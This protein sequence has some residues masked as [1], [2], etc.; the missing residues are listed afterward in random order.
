MGCDHKIKT[1]TV[2]ENIMCNRVHGGDKIHN[3]LSRFSPFWK[4]WSFPR[5]KQHFFKCRYLKNSSFRKITCNFYYIL[6]RECPTSKSNYDCCILLNLPLFMA[7]FALSGPI[8]KI[9]NSKQVNSKSYKQLSVCHNIYNSLRPSV[10]WLRFYS[11]LDFSQ[12]GNLS[13]SLFS[14]L[15]SDCI[16]LD[17]KEISYLV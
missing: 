7:N 3:C 5:I 14:V 4:F 13:L 2:C 15:R 1:K 6:G 10:S 17:F 11:I 9:R 12:S 16:E 8:F